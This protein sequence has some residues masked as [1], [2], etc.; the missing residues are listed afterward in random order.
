MQNRKT[1]EN[2]P[3]A[4]VIQEKK[5]AKTSQAAP[6]ETKLS[7]TKSCSNTIFEAV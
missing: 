3:Y 7:L 1:T 4:K 6:P 2:F 5:L